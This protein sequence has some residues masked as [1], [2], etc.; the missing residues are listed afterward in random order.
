[1]LKLTRTSPHQTSPD[2]SPAEGGWIPEDK[3]RLG[4]EPVD[5]AAVG[6]E[7]LPFSGLALS[8]EEGVG[9][10]LIGAELDPCPVLELDAHEALSLGE[11]AQPRGGGLVVSCGNNIAAGINGVGH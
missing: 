10:G 3:D 4:G 11:G 8:I 2:A 7:D 5:V 1:M 9:G 6:L